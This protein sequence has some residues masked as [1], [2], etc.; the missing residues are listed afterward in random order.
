MENGWRR[1]GLAAL[2]L[3]HAEHRGDLGQHMLAGA[4]RLQVDE[5]GARSELGLQPAGQLDS[6]PGLAAATA[7]G[8]RHQA[9]AGQ[10]VS[11]PRDLR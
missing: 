5:P 7:A 11:G 3:F 10:Q 9:I 8:H 6:Q 2:R 1:Q 4:Q